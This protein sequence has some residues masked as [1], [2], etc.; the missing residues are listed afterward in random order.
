MEPSLKQLQVLADRYGVAT[1][2]RDGLGRECRPGPEAVAEI[3]KALGCPMDSPIEA[4]ETRALPPAVVRFGDGTSLVELDPRVGHSF[5]ADL[6]LEDG[7]SRAL[8]AGDGAIQIPDGLPHGIHTLNLEFGSVR[9]SC[10]LLCAPAT[11]YPPE[12]LFPDR[13]W[14]LFLPLYAARSGPDSGVGDL[15]D[16]ERL[17]DWTGS[18]GGSLVGVLPMNAAFLDRPYAPSPFTP[19]S[20]LFWNELFLDVEGVGGAGAADTVDY[21]TVMAAKRK[22]LEAAAAGSREY[23]GLVEEDPYLLPYARFRAETERHGTGWKIWPEGPRSG[24]LTVADTDPAVQYHLY[25]QWLFHDRLG[26]I[27]SQEKPG[28]ELYSDL[29]L[30]VHPDSFDTWAHPALFASGVT[31]GA[32]PDVMFSNGQN[33]GFPPLLPEA[34][35]AEGY[36][37]VTQTIRRQAR[38]ASMLRIDHVMGLHRQFWIPEGGDPSE[39][40]Y[41]TFPADEQ[42]AILAMESH[43]NRCA[44]AGEDLGV[45]PDGVREAMA[46]HRIQR[47]YV[48]QFRHP[49]SSPSQEM[50][51]ALNTHDLRPFAG[52]LEGLDIDDRLQHGFMAP[53]AEDAARAQRTESFRLAAA[54]LVEAGF[55]RHGN[56]EPA[57]LLDAWLQWLG[58]GPARLVLVNAEDLWLETRAHNVPGTRDDR[59]NWV[60]RSSQSLLDMEQ[61][62]RI[63]A[64]LQ[65]LTAARQPV[66]EKR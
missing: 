13:A 15:G 59:P 12:R 22:V 18:L 26:K 6:E 16:L 9:E 35:R 8:P 49:P 53:D 42:Y 32:P 7:R 52:F 23:R 56:P 34:N 14:G 10:L 62:D 55:L 37:Y 54:A 66:K 4:V 38:F 27:V 45:V 57:V 46:R 5:A 19:A 40:T 28:R 41:V 64:M 39:G 44:V 60:G 3:L 11:V 20:R 33:W 51:A 58:A 48:G 36:R 17:M 47:L 65:R 29:P 24:E 61:S 25:V 30:G 21:R 43:R 50:V 63:T 2:Y 31:V 1:V